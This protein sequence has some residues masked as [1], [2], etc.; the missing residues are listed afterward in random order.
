MAHA[1]A[2]QGRA[3]PQTHRGTTGRAH[4][5]VEG[6]AH[7][8]KQEKRGPNFTLYCLIQTAMVLVL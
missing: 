2:N 3:H 4:L 7:P 5:L 6:R 1:I 8:L